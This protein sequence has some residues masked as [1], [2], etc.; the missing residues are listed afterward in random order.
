MKPRINK[1]GE[2]RTPVHRRTELRTERI[3]ARQA[4][5]SDKPWGNI[6]GAL[7]SLVAVISPIVLLFFYYTRTHY[8]PALLI[9][10]ESFVM[11]ISI[12]LFLITIADLVLSAILYFVLF[13]AYTVLGGNDFRGE[14]LNLSESPFGISLIRLIIIPSIVGICI[15][16]NYFFSVAFFFGFFPKIPWI[17]GPFPPLIIAVL[18]YFVIHVAN[19]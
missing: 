4:G 18:A 9:H 5:D 10:E 6:V 12:G 17:I 7:L 16:T 15:G 8:N 3:V 11:Y 2:I 14:L 1:Y 19:E 13:A